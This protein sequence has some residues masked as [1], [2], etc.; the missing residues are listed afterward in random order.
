MLNIVLVNDGAK[1]GISHLQELIDR[2]KISC[3]RS[4]RWS[5]GIGKCT[6]YVHTIEGGLYSPVANGVEFVKTRVN[7]SL[8]QN[9][10]LHVLPVF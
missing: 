4:L 7:F 6:E 5:A 3:R 9:K 1:H 8:W 10:D 2:I